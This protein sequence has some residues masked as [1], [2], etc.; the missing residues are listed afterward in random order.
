[1]SHHYFLSPHPDDAV[2]SCG[3]LIA[4]YLSVGNEVTV[5]TVFDGD[6]DHIVDQRDKDSWRKIAR[7]SLRRAENQRVLSLLGAKEMSIGLADASLRATSGKYTYKD[8]AALFSHIREEDKKLISMLSARLINMIG[9]DGILHAPIGFSD[10]V[11]HQIVFSSAAEIEYELKDRVFWYEE[12]GYP[13]ATP[14]SYQ[15]NYQKVD[16]EIWLKAASLYRS[17]VI[18][19]YGSQSSFINALHEWA[20]WNKN[21]DYPGAQDCCWQNKRKDV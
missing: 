16:F 14:V 17:Q 19:L 4:H 18:Y 11:D 5:V 12:F 20:H 21:I 10:H 1:M 8:R 6:E 2:W 9:V 3:G 7:P 15:P 13:K